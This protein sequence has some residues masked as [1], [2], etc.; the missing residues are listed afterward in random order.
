MSKS[1]NRAVFGILFLVLLF[2]M[3]LM[4]SA[5]LTMKAFQAESRGF[6][7]G[8]GKHAIGVI[9]VEGIIMDSKKIV[10]RLHKAERDPRVKAILFRIESPGGAVGPTQEIYE[11]IRRIDQNY[12]RKLNGETIDF[13]ERA[14]PIYASFGAIAASGGYYI[15]AAAREIYANPGTMTGSIGVIMQFMDLSRLYEFAKVSPQTVKSGQF[16]DLGQP[17]RALTR[18]EQELMDGMV[19]TVHTQFV[20]D[21]LKLREKKL[22]TDIWELAQGQIFSGQEAQEAGLID[23]LGS[24]WEAARTIHKSLELEGELNLVYFKE[25]ERVGLLDFFQSLEQVATHLGWMTQGERTPRLM[26]VN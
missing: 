12:T 17:H 13:P 15:G 8:G 11:E 23:H 16:K 24:L 26:F 4:V 5:H 2:F 14:K 10:E 20:Q 6:S 9:E 18:Q 25:R 19:K 7:L 1:R 22:T 21:I 3:M